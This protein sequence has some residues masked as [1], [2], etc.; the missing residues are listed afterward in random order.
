[1]GNNASESIKLIGDIKAVVSQVCNCYWVWVQWGCIIRTWINFRERETHNY[2]GTVCSICTFVT[3]DFEQ[4]V[5]RS[6]LPLC[7]L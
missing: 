1:M 3:N 5:W 6:F 7:A 2:T 4:I